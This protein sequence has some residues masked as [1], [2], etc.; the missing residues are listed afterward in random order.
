MDRPLS[1]QATLFA[2]PNGFA[3]LP[4]SGPHS[5]ASLE[6]TGGMTLGRGT[7][8]VTTASDSNTIS[9]THDKSPNAAFRIHVS[10]ME[11]G[12]SAD[13]S[14]AANAKQGELPAVR[15]PSGGASPTEIAG[16]DLPLSPTTKEPSLSS[17]T[18]SSVSP[19]HAA[20][21]AANPWDP[22]SPLSP[23]REGALSPRGPFR[24]SHHACHG[25]TVGYVVSPRWSM[26]QG[27]AHGGG[28]PTPPLPL[29]AIHSQASLPKSHPSPRIA[30]AASWDVDPMLSNAMFQRKSEELRHSSSL[31]GDTSN[32]LNEPA[33][34]MSVWPAVS[35]SPAAKPLL[36]QLEAG[37][38]TAESREAKP[39]FLQQLEDRLD[40]DLRGFRRGSHVSG[41]GGTE[42]ADASAPRPEEPLN[43]YVLQA[44]GSVFQQFIDGFKAYAPLLSK[45]K[46][47]YERYVHR[48][49]ELEAD[50]DRL[51][52]SVATTAD[53][54][55]VALEEE[56]SRSH[57]AL[58]RVTLEREDALAKL[59]NLEAD[60]K[61]QGTTVV[62]LERANKKL[63]A[64]VEEAHH[65]NRVVLSALSHA[66]ETAAHWKKEFMQ[67]KAKVA[68]LQ[69]SLHSKLSVLMCENQQLQEENA[70][71]KANHIIKSAPVE[72]AGCAAAHTSKSLEQTSV[73]HITVQG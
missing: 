65:Q 47:E 73:F 55:A 68:E 38:A 60:F 29:A 53:Q 17:T 11:S 69:S 59:K 62:M 1:Q 5:A 18:K 42:G 9:P 57:A 45:I 8:R 25:G 23:P 31:L 70:R 40:N 2:G 43:N 19:T 30:R 37:V 24:V 36:P 54:Q 44:Y 4:T 67:E 72:A 63:E 58:E 3:I 64:K 10:R 56:R 61:T 41:M 12:S 33:S 66:E 27:V 16:G 32:F 51:Q 35:R 46:K 22:P 50:V 34:A 7:R 49:W 13:P 28:S 48:V 6:A 21:H 39:R 14:G 20:M 71:L 15:E 52:M 26:N